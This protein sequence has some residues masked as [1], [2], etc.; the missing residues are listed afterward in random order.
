[1]R[2][3]L[4]LLAVVMFAQSQPPYPAPRKDTQG[5]QKESAVKE[6]LV[7]P[8]K[9][10]T[11]PSPITVN[12]YAS[13]YKEGDEQPKSNAE[14]NKSAFSEWTIAIGTVLLFFATM[15]LAL[16]TAALCVV[17][18]LQWRTMIRHE[19][20]FTGIARSMNEGLD[21][22]KIAADAAKQ[23]ADALKN[24]ERAWVIVDANSSTKPLP[25]FAQLH[26]WIWNTGKTPAKITFTK[27]HL[28]VLAPNVQLP[29][30]PTYPIIIAG[31]EHNMIL[32][33]GRPDPGTVGNFGF[34]QDIN[35]APGVLNAI[36]A[37]Q[38]IV[39][40]YGEVGY[41]DAFGD[42]RKTVFGFRWAGGWDREVPEAY[43]ECT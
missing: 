22:T 1:M 3:A 31:S 10:Q 34:T 23:S 5:K 25:G 29:E 9:N 11:P 14:Q 19:E 35:L 2:Y 6:Q 43:N 17:A 4:L 39:Y 18:I 42:D 8:D 27:S 7:Q 38:Q 21:A 15:W 13:H 33:M 30:T 20:A 36:Q 37:G 28:V 26:F 32:A 12:Q 40:V 16:A 41:K 24:S